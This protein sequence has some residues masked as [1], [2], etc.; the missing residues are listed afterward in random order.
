MV[1]PKGRELVKATVEKR[2][3]YVAAVDKFIKQ[4][5]DAKYDEALNFMQGDFRKAQYAYF[6]QLE[7]F[8]N[9]LVEAM[10]KGNK[11]ADDNYALARMLM[12][13]MAVVAV[14]IGIL[15][16]LFTTRSITRPLGEAVKVAE[17]VASGDLTARIEVRSKDE[18][19]QL[20]QALK[21]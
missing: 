10:N 16:A 18:T 20:M 8:Q 4:F 12:I 7:A 1:T 19:G 9:Y 13:A 15:V 5:D 11:E 21:N 14:V 2:T 6:E 3:A 17:T